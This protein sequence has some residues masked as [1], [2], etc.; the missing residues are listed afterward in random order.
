MGVS[1]NKIKGHEFCSRTQ[2]QMNKSVILTKTRKKGIY[3]DE[4]PGPAIIQG[5]GLNSQKVKN[6]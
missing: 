3:S 5:G 4:L 1:F 6:D 2:V